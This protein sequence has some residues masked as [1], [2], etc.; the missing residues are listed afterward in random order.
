MERVQKKGEDVQEQW[1]RKSEI[2]KKKRKEV[3]VLVEVLEALFGKGPPPDKEYWP[4]NKKLWRV[5]KE[6]KG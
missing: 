5:I 6:K 3:L 2:L 1:I 4:W